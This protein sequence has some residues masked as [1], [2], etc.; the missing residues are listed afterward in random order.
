M[1]RLE[2]A[3]D[4]TAFRL[5]RRRWAARAS[6]R[7]EES[8]AGESSVERRHDLPCSGVIDLYSRRQNDY[9]VDH[10]LPAH[11]DNFQ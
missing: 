11:A 7:G 3:L 2:T 4:E 1:D 9:G 8:G 5:T 6:R 10:Y